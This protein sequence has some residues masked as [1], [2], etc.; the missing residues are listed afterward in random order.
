MNLSIIL[1]FNL[2][3]KEA[4]DFYK[5]CFGG[6]IKSIYTYS[7]LK[8]MPSIYHD[9]IYHSDFESE[10]IKFSVYDENDE[11]LSYKGYE[12][13]PN[14]EEKK[15]CGGCK[16]KSKNIVE[17]TIENIKSEKDQTEIFEKL[18]KD[19]K[20]EI[21]LQKTSWGSI[22]GKVID[23]YGINWNLIFFLGKN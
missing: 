3:A 6:E 4:L 15:C 12:N 13:L 9:K 19:G 20:I 17:I 7:M 10:N 21:P 22:F 1:K 11:I 2:N 23:K 5:E 14:K 18:S 16:N 8:D